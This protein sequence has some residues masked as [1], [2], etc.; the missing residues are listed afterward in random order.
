MKTP[1][2]MSKTPGTTD[3]ITFSQMKQDMVK[4]ARSFDQL[5]KVIN[6]TATDVADVKTICG[7]THLLMKSM[8]ANSSEV[9]KIAS[10]LNDLSKIHASSSQPSTQSMSQPSFSALLTPSK[11]ISFSNIVKQQQ[12]QQRIDGRMTPSAKR[13]LNDAT[14]TKTT[15]TKPKD[16]PP[17]KMGKRTGHV[18][19]AV[20]PAPI[21]TIRRPKPNDVQKSDSPAFDKSLHVSRIATSMTV[22]DMNNFITSETSLVPN[23]DFKCTRLVKK[24]QSIE[25]LSFISFKIDYFEEKCA[26]LAEEDFWPDGAMIRPFIPSHTLGDFLTKSPNTSNRRP[27]KMA[28]TTTEKNE[29]QPTTPMQPIIH[30]NEPPKTDA[31]SDTINQIDLTNENDPMELH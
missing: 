25:T 28:K 19:L 27:N 31:N 6:T 5:S 23:V 2:S 30:S 8:K 15:S 4:L 16:I 11:P 21:K 26:L 12:I 7:D 17:A 18:A 9:T 14:T 29:I 10:K 13:K 3:F 22:D 24:D 1:L 20:A